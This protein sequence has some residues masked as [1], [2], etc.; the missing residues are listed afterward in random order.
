MPRKTT[1]Y[2]VSDFPKKPRNL[3]KPKKTVKWALDEPTKEQRITMFRKC[4]KCI[5]VPPK[6]GDDLS[7]ASNYKFPVCTKLGKTKGKCQFNC[8]GMIAANRRARLTKM[9]PQ[10]VDLTA[11]LINKW[12]CTKKAEKEAMTKKVVLKAKPKKVALKAKPKKVVSKP[13]PKRQVLK[14]KAVLKPKPKTSL[15]KKKKT[16]TKKPVQKKT[17]TTKKPVQKKRTTTTTKKLVM[18]KTHKS[19]K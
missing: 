11:K 1:P 13:K 3:K 4:P 5:L 14:K 19:K 2:R 12:Q 16:T 6:P 9:Y 7:D 8:S 17:T 10:V 18:K 15:V